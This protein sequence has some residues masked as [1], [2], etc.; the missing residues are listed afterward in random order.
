MHLTA[1]AI[2]EILG[3]SGVMIIYA[4]IWRHAPVKFPRSLDEWWAW[5]RGANQEI[6]AQRS[7]ASASANPTNPTTPEEPAK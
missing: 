1:S 4:A 5:I 7:G 2:S 6:A 3:G